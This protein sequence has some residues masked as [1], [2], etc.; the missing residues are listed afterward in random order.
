MPELNPRRLTRPQIARIV[1][2]DPELIK[3]F[4]ALFSVTGG[5]AD[6]ITLLTLL[7]DIAQQTADT[8]GAQLAAVQGQIERIASA[9]EMLALAPADVPAQPVEDLRDCPTCAAT[10][11]ECAAL[12]RRV[13]DLESAP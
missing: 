8:A 10:R 5:N 11:E 13:A 2:N 9:V 3:A 1:G 6:D 4:E 7:T 12:A